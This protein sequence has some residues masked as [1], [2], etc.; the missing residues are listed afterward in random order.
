MREELKRGLRVGMEAAMM[1]TFISRLWQES[2]E[3]HI[4]QRGRK[5][6]LKIRWTHMAQTADWIEPP[7]MY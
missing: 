4:T 3:G 6:D 7:M 5:Y 1:P 2:A